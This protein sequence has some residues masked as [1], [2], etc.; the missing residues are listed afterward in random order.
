MR[1]GAFWCKWNIDSPFQASVSLNGLSH[2]PG[3]PC[4]W[5]HVHMCGTKRQWQPSGNIKTIW[6][7]GMGGGR[8]KNLFNQTVSEISH[9]FEKQVGLNTSR[10]PDL[11][12][13]WGISVN[14]VQ[15]ADDHRGN[16][17]IGLSQKTMGTAVTLL[18]ARCWQGRLTAPS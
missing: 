5:R 15:V 1:C 14:E 8:G 13:R 6:P 3:R 2:V 7:C 17:W 12:R 9:A 18:L 10:R 16:M 11:K 4:Q